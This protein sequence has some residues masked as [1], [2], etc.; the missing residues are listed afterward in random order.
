MVAKLKALCR[1]NEVQLKIRVE[2]IE[3]QPKIDIRKG[4]Q[5][6]VF[7]CMGFINFYCNKRA[8]KLIGIRILN[9]VLG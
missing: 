3:V 5:K 8:K 4:T 9:I 7:K 2:L 1:V 6:V